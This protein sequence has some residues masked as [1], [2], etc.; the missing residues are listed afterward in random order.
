MTATETSTGVNRTVST[1]PDGT[2]RLTGLLA[3]G[4]TLKFEMPGFSPLALTLPTPLSAHES[5][6]LAS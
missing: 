3:G 4:Y 5:A 1:D 6:N 2:F